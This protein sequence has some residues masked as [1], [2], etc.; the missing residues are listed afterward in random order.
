MLGNRFE[1]AIH[2]RIQWMAPHEQYAELNPLDEEWFLE[3]F[4]QT[5]RLLSPAP[6]STL[7]SH[8]N[9]ALSGIPLEPLSRPSSHWLGGSREPLPLSNR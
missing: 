7:P 3:D 8:R 4:T 2:D 6:R 1:P 9:P 5:C